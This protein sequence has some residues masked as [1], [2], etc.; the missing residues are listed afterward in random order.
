G[1]IFLDEI[2]E[3]PVAMQVKL[4]R[5]LQEK[6]FEYV[7]GSVSIKIDVRII[8]ATNRNL[9]KEIG[10][11]NFRLDLYY[12]L[13]VFP[14]LLPPLRERR[15][16]IPALA[17]YFAHKFCRSFN[18]TFN[19][20]APSMADELYG[21]NWPGNIRELEN[22]IEQAVV[23]NDGHSPLNLTK[24][25]SADLTGIPADLT[26]HT[27]EGIRHSQRETERAYI[28]AAL[29]QTKGRIRGK[30]GAAELLKIKPTTLESKMARLHI[31]RMDF[32]QP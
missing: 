4:L 7:G 25:L 14:I 18:K 20:I 15:S 22:V 1:T 16:D 30:N 23:L 5:V 9:E 13:N 10:D 31:N 27:M 24:K 28:N 8:T 11:G 19:G 32:M 17:D 29:K 26:V 2:G 6:E 3:L 21:Y 12:R